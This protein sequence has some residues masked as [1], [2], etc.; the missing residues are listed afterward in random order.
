[1]RMSALVNALIAG[2]HQRLVRG[3]LSGALFLVLLGLGYGFILWQIGGHMARDQ[4]AELTRVAEAR[5]G[6]IT[7]LHLLRL[8]ATAAPCSREFLAQMQKIAFLPDGLNEF[9]YAPDGVAKC[10]TSQPNFDSPVN[11]GAPDIAAGFGASWRVPFWCGYI[12]PRPRGWPDSRPPTFCA[13]SHPPRSP[14]L[15]GYSR[16]LWWHGGCGTLWR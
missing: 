8:E 3:I 10:S 16:R 5:T 15:P 4:Q 12:A 13:P 9:I 11:L 14:I 6:A 2:R 1:M 7:A